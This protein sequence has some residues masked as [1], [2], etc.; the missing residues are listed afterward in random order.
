VDFDPSDVVIKRATIKVQDYLTIKESHSDIN[1]FYLDSI[2]VKRDT[3][4]LMINHADYY[5]EWR[6]MK[7]E[8]SRQ[9]DLRE[10]GD[11]ELEVLWAPPTGNW[12]GKDRTILYLSKTD[13]IIDVLYQ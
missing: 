8:E 1:D 3:I 9:K 4:I 6:M 2:Y 13:S 11:T 12:S 10:R 5:I 7:E